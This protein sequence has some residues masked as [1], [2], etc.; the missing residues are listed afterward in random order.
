MVGWVIRD[1]LL[2][3]TKEIDDV[4]L[5]MAGEP[6]T[7]WKQ[8]NWKTKKEREDIFR[9]EKFGTMTIIKS[10]QKL[11]GANKGEQVEVPPFASDVDSRAQS[12]WQ[13]G[14]VKYEIT[15]LREESGYSDMRH[16]DQIVWSNNL[17]ADA[18]RRDFSINA[19]YYSQVQRL[20]SSKV[21]KPKEFDY[22]ANVIK[23]LENNWYVVIDDFLIIQNHEIING[24][25]PNGKLSESDYK[26]FIKEQK[27]DESEISWILRDPYNGIQDLLDGKLKCVW[28]A[29]RRF[30]EDPLR[31]LRAIRFVNTLNF[32]PDLED[33]GIDFE[34]NTWKSMKKNYYLVKSLSKER[35]HEE[36]QKVFSANNPFAYVAVLDELNLLKFLFP[37]VHA[38]KNLTQPVRY[39][40]FD[41][42][43]HTL[44][45][46][47]HLQT[48]NVSYLVRIAMLYH[49]VGKVEQYHTHSFNLEENERSFIYSGRL[50]H[51]NCGPDLA[52]E[53]LARIGFGNKEI[54]EV[55]R[56][57]ANH[58]KPGEILFS[59]KENR[60]K[61]LRELYAEWGYDWTKNLLDICTG[62]RAGHYNPI[63][64][65]EISK[66]RL[67]YDLLDELRDSEGQFTMSK[68]EIDGEV[69]MKE[70]KLN[71]GKKVWEL[72]KKAYEWVM[73]DVK[74]RN[75]KE[76]ILKYLISFVNKK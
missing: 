68:M 29:D 4:D 63:Q 72:M 56:Y 50:N 61:K 46:L 71:P 9:T 66:V 48:I 7:I 57:I 40:P 76:K 27:L 2:G 21:K 60:K 45:A 37:A 74:I 52:E 17:I 54:N 26:R 69:I 53:D 70:F 13:S 19:M 22:E 28:I 33:A 11:T 51:V 39:H 41:V 38:I 16:P 55:R 75:T 32:D 5:T 23:Q 15:P 35:I 59:K 24:L 42:Y 34:K 10:E 3:K 8:I 1:C 12:G 30:I 14:G 36:I 44:L 64:K 58:M 43:S 62:D 73:D 47:H 18:G 67:L 31:I 49:D 6:D 20:K 65:P 25:L